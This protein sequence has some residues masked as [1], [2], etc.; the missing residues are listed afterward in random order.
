MSKFSYRPD[1]Q[2]PPAPL[3]GGIGH[4]HPRHVGLNLGCT[5][6]YTQEHSCCVCI[7]VAL[8]QVVWKRL[9]ADSAIDKGIYTE[10]ITMYHQGLSLT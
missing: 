8:M 10:S 1:G 9:Y 4:L 2:L 7:I 6:P 3:Q 5:L